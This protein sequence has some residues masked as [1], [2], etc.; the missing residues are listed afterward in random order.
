[1]ADNESVETR[2]TGTRTRE[3][4]EP[5][6]RRAGEQRGERR[7]RSSSRPR[8]GQRRRGRK[9]CNFC[10]DNIDR[11]DYKDVALLNNYVNERGR[12]LPRR[13]TGTCA[14]HQRRLSVAIKRARHVALMPFAA[15]HV[16][17]FD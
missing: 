9:V 2:E 17:S 12:V 8:G 1:M 11:I 4:P 14:K 6:E 15:Q 7:A 3:A 13:R 16:R 5:A 10:A